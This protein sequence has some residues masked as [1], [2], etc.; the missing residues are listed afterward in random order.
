MAVVGAGSAEADTINTA[1]AVG[2]AIAE[3]GAMLVCGGLGGV[4]E[5]A[6]KGAKSAGGTTIGILPQ[7]YRHDANPYIDVPIATGF[8]EGR[9][10][11]IIR[12][13]DVVIA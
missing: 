1:E 2:R 6:A 11:F 13:A 9:N 4:M 5:A 12:T 10:V 3:R 8:G 7:P